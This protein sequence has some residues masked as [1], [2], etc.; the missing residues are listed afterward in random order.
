[1]ME[2]FCSFVNWSSFAEQ[3][4]YNDSVFKPEQHERSNLSPWQELHEPEK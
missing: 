1:M 4:P 3:W 2:K